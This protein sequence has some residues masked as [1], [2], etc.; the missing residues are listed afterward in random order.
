MGKAFQ[1]RR[2]QDV[3]AV[4]HMDVGNGGQAWNMPV[5]SLHGCIYGV[6]EKPYP[7]S[8]CKHQN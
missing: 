6:P 3:F 2:K 4:T 5:Q 1:E 7:F 8:L